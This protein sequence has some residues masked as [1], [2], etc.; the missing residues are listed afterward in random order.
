MES[1]DKLTQHVQFKN[2]DNL[3]IFVISV[4]FQRNQNKINVKKIQKA[5]KIVKHGGQ[6][7]TMVNIDMARRFELLSQ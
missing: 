1:R 4:L 7:N 5:L 6:C 3:G 2:K